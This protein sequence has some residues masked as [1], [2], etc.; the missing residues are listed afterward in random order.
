MRVFSPLM[1]C[2]IGIRISRLLGP[3]SQRSARTEPF[4]LALHVSL[5]VALLGTSAPSANV[6][7][8]YRIRPGDFLAVTVFGEPA[9]TQAQLKVLPGGAI[10]EPLAGEIRVG[11]LTTPEAAHSVSG[12]LLKYLRSPEVTVAVDQV[13]PVDVYV[14]GNV[15]TPGKYTLGSDSKLM[16]ALA[17]AG[18]IGP[19]DGDL[20]DARIVGSNVS[21]VSF[22]KALA[23]GR[24][25]SRCCGI[26]MA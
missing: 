9:L 6:S 3:K 2:E 14:L 25:H 11:G 5:F 21:R 1:S 19:T 10:V 12:A 22:A 23:R 20:P 8:D 4:A 16:N 15:R 13:G 18:G 17:A 26:G 24:P 7:A